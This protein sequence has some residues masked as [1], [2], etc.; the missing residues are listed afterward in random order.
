MNRAK[1]AGKNFNS[2]RKISGFRWLFEFVIG[3]K[4]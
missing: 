4:K 1:P 3:G 2:V